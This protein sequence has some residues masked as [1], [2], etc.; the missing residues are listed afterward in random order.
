MWCLPK[1]SSYVAFFEFLLELFKGYIQGKLHVLV[2]RNIDLVLKLN[3]K[4][5]YELRL[6]DLL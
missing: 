4:I 3:S 1:V 2:W 6:K 5:F